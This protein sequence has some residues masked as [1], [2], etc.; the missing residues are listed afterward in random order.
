LKR[1]RWFAA[2]WPIPLRTLATKMKEHAF[3][4]DS[5]DGFIIDRVRDN[6][7]GGRYIEKVSFQ[8]TITDP[9]GNQQTFE[10]IFYRQLEFN[11]FST[12]PNM[13]LWDAPRSTQA[14]LSR[15]SELSSFAASV[16]SLSVDLI[17]WVNVFQSI[18][19]AKIMID[20]VQISGL[21][22]EK[23]VTARVVITGDKDVREA[24]QHIAKNRRYELEKLHL[25]LLQASTIV[26]IQLGN[27][28]AVKLDEAY[29]E[30]YVPAL[31]DALPRPKGR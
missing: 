31:R 11:L 19:K 20:S 1:V 29:V 16:T 7:V 3:K 4:E 27:T 21:E 12:F 6:L 28:G 15:L 17:K 14:Y 30:D 23:G 22:I 18:T 13:E 26:P 2:T 5:L 8:E 9:F 10:R 25:K 24:I